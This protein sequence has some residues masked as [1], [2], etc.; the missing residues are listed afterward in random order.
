[1]VVTVMNWLV[2]LVVL[3]GGVGSAGNKLGIV[4]LVASHGGVVWGVGGG[5]RG[6]RHFVSYRTTRRDMTRHETKRN[7]L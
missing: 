2:V 6:F 5:A 7:G 4:A 3:D 1:M